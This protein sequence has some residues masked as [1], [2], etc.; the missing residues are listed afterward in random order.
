MSSKTVSPAHLARLEKRKIASEEGAQALAE[1]EARAVAV[2]QNME[3]L[4]ALRLA[5]EA[6]EAA[7]AP[8]ATKKR[9]SG[10]KSGGRSAG[11]SAVGKSAR[12]KKGDGKGQSQ[13]LSAWLASQRDSGRL[14]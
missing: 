13:P 9:A 3:R 4:R 5:K 2:R 8:A 11:K 12:G 6:Q 10:G 14:R 1:Q 7:H